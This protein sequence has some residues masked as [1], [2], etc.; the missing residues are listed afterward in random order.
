MF[1]SLA[2]EGNIAFGASTKGRSSQG[3]DF[4]DAAKSLRQKGGEE[5]ENPNA[6][7]KGTPAPVCLE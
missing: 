7:F 3:H 2:L 6:I 4:I 5:V 1:L